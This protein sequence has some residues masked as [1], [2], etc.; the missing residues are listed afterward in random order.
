MLGTICMRIE[1]RFLGN[2]PPLL[3]PF[4]TVLALHFFHL[5]QCPCV[6]EVLN[7]FELA[8]GVWYSISLWSPGFGIY[9]TCPNRILSRHQGP[10]VSRI[11]HSANYSPSDLTFFLSWKIDFVENENAPLYRRIPLE[12]DIALA[13]TPIC[14]LKTMAGPRYTQVFA[15]WGYI[16]S[17][18][19]NVGQCPLRVACAWKHAGET[20]WVLL[21]KHGPA[22]MCSQYMGNG[23][24]SPLMVFHQ[25]VRSLCHDDVEGKKYYKWLKPTHFFI[26]NNPHSTRSAQNV[27]CCWMRLPLVSCIPL[28]H[29]S[30]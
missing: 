4:A 2:G 26:Y 28:A 25:H 5:C 19:W 23:Q 9:L 27:V 11:N 22:P 15:V 6:D 17:C 13:L 24:L 3:K 21:P 20:K 18:S 30:K 7:I 16:P 8:C 1:R 10:P 29:Q 14:S 12:N